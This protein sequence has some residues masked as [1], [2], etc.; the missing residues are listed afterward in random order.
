[1]NCTDIPQSRK[2]SDLENVQLKT[3]LVDLNQNKVKLIRQCTVLLHTMN[4]HKKIYIYIY[5]QHIL[6][7]QKK[8]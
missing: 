1:M 3:S 7:Q 4:I 8:N 6:L 2:A 5:V